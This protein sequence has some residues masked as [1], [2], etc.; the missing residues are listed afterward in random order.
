MR[1]RTTG[2]LTPPPST[3]ALIF[4]WDGT[5]ADST[6]ANYL[7]LR[8]AL[9]QHGHRLPRTWFEQRTGLSAE[10]VARAY[11][12]EHAV[13]LDEA[14]VARH[15]ADAYLRY[16]VHT[17]EAVT[18]V[19]TVARQ[20]LLRGRRLAIATGGNARTFEPTLDHLGIRELFAVIVTRDE[21]EH[22]KPAPDLFDAAL[23][24]LRVR[25]TEAIVYE[26]SEE[27]LLAAEAAGILAID[28]R[29]LLATRRRTSAAATTGGDVGAAAGSAGDRSEHDVLD[30]LEE[31]HG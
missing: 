19:V 16:H 5:L 8:H 9:G 10:D 26:D 18:P 30:E 24:R 4:D 17:V 15:R 13:E 1:A 29:P 23:K 22:G 21:V 27:G 20:A 28:V 14:A 2:D 25:P 31:R 6:T 7:S 12:D 3:R 11:A